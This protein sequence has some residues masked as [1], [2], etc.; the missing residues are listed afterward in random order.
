MKNSGSGPKY[1]MSPIP[2]CL[3]YCSAF[4]AIW[5]GSS[6]VRLVGDGV[7]D[8]ADQRQR[9]L[10]DEGI[11]HRAVGVGMKVMSDSLIAFQPRMEL[12][13]KL[14]PSVNESSVS[15]WIGMVVCCH[16][17]RRSTNLKSTSLTPFFFANSRPRLGTCAVSLLRGSRGV[18]F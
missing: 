3:R 2:V 11:D 17:P 9:G 13:S 5:R 12:P 4:R 1:E 18:F 15:L 7:R 16:W 14:K 6:S 10:L 8:V